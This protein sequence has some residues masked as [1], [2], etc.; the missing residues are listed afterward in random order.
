MSNN[1]ARSVLRRHRHARVRHNIEGSIERPRLAV[2][3]S[4]RHIYAQVINDAEGHTLAAASTLDHELAGEK[5]SPIEAA[6]RVGELCA[7]RAVEAGVSCVVFDRGGYQFHGRVA[8]LAEGAR[9]KGLQ[10]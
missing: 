7:Q 8:A 5:V 1:S 4:N 9:A 2:F 10:F 6:K 3:R